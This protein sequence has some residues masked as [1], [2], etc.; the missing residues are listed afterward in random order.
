MAVSPADFE[1]YSRATGAPYPRNPE[2]RMRMA[3]EVHQYAQNYARQPSNLQKAAGVLG[4]TA[5]LGGLLAGAYGISKVLGP[6]TGAVASAMADQVIS[7][8]N[9]P[10]EVERPPQE[11]W[12]PPKGT[13]SMQIARKEQELEDLRGSQP[14]TPRYQRNPVYTKENY[15]NPRKNA[16]NFLMKITGGGSDGNV[17]LYDPNEGGNID[18]RS[19]YKP[20]SGWDRHRGA[21]EQWA[22]DVILEQKI[23]NAAGPLT[24]GIGI[25]N[26]YDLANMST[27]G[28]AFGNAFTEGV[29]EGLNRGALGV[30]DKDPGFKAVHTAA[31]AISGG[32][33]NAMETISSWGF[34]KGHTMGDLVQYIA[35]HGQNL[36]GVENVENVL[37]AVG[38]VAHTAPIE[39]TLMGGTVAGAAALVGGARGAKKTKEVIDNA[40]SKG[41]KQLERFK[42]VAEG[43]EITVKPINEKHPQTERIAPNKAIHTGG[44]IQGEEPGLGAHVESGSPQTNRRREE[45]RETFRKSLGTVSPEE[46]EALIDQQLEKES[47]SKGLSQL[48]NFVNKAFSSGTKK[49]EGAALISEPQEEEVPDWDP[50]VKY[51]RSSEGQQGPATHLIRRTAEYDANPSKRYS[52]ALG[53]STDIENE[54]YRTDIYFRASPKASGGTGVQKRSYYSDDPAVGRQLEYDALDTTQRLNNPV[55]GE[56]IYMMSEGDLKARSFM[57]SFAKRKKEGDLRIAVDDEGNPMK[58]DDPWWGKGEQQQGSTEWVRSPD[59]RLRKKV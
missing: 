14:E 48:K 40:V 7:S 37:R 46:R 56:D 16:E 27:G 5:Q 12:Q 13:K 38:H 33:Q 18:I 57:K 1:L 36:P 9:E 30:L 26:I 15:G 35:Q 8:D 55:T 53:V 29:T 47:N 4:R 28:E 32:A 24:A 51:V 43:K 6:Q 17:S 20:V 21:V 3:P 23:A 42:R 50:T 44:D 25:K 10:V 11:P 2:E 19:D 54:P 41:K 34:G 31:D 22:D 58:S 52:G 39:L 59:G 49:E 45:L